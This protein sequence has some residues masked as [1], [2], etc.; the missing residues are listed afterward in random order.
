MYREYEYRVYTRKYSTILE[1]YLHESRYGSHESYYVLGRLVFHFSRADLSPLFMLFFLHMQFVPTFLALCFILFCPHFSCSFLHM[2]FVPTFLALCFILFCPHFSCSFLHMHF[3]PT[4]L[5]I[6][7]IAICPHLAC[8]FCH[9]GIREST[10]K[11]HFTTKHLPK[12]QVYRL[13]LTT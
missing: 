13:L 3:V 2:H 12:I 11:P 7:F 9:S 1:Y 6:L 8:S 4:F 10:Y 5:S